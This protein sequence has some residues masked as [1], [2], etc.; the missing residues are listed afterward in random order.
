MPF[1]SDVKFLLEEKCVH[2]KD[3]KALE[4]WGLISM[5]KLSLIADG[6]AG[7]RATIAG[8][9]KQDAADPDGLRGIVAV[10]DAWGTATKRIEVQRQQEAEAKGN[11]LPKTVTKSAL[12]SLRHSAEDVVGAISDKLAPGAALL[13]LVFEQVE[14]HA[15]EAIPLTQVVCVEDGE[16][17]KTSAVVDASGVVR[18]K[19]G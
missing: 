17:L 16:E 12:L 3:V 7:A 8:L 11:Q 6:R 18:V 10:L 1:Q 2:E 4:A 15:I 9:L 14:E 13:E 5:S 19:R